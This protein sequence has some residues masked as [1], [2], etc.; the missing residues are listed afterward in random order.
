MA[1]EI[2]N[3]GCLQGIKVIDLTRVLAGPFCTM[4]LA[5]MGAEIIKVEQKG[6]GDDTREYPPFLNGISAY[7]ANLNRNKRSIDLDLKSPGDKEI[8]FELIRTAD[9]VVENFK[10]GTMEKFGFSYD[11]MKE[12]NPEIIYASISGFG[13]TGRYKNR[14]GYDIIGQAMGGIMSVSGWPGMP[15]T[16]TGTAISDILG[17]LNACVGILAA[18]RG[19]EKFGHGDRLDVSLVDSTISSMET[20]LQIYLVEQRIPEPIGNRYE[21]IYPYDTF[22]AADGW[23]VIACGN[24][25][26]WKRLCKVME[27]KDLVEIGRFDSNAKRVSFHSELF[28]IISGWTRKFSK[29]EI[30]KKLLLNSIPTCQIYNVKE[31]VEDPHIAEDREMII[32]IPHP[33][34]GNMKVV[35]TPIKFHNYQ[36]LKNNPAPLLG[37]HREEILKELLTLAFIRKEEGMDTV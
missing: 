3:R 1:N 27:R 30:E 12:A 34:E 21:F 20:L 26:I 5:E 19:K 32:E 9:V 35:G 23:I 2:N 17:G 8:L 36:L 31:I 10:P 18:I 14:P 33:V 28:D 37:Q 15:P 24:D 4:L 6:K 16:R 25:A 29:S 7:F 13:Q 22:P 11:K